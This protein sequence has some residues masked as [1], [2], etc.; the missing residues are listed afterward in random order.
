MSKRELLVLCGTCIALLFFHA[1]AITSEATA[2]EAAA[3]ELI[4]DGVAQKVDIQILSTNLA[5]GNTRGEWGLSALVKV[6]GRCILFD[7]GRFPDTVVENA[8]A[9]RADLSCVDTIVLSHFHFDHTGGLLRLVEAI[10]PSGEGPPIK[11]YVAEGFFTPRFLDTDKAVG[12]AMADVFGV[13]WNQMIGLKAELEQK[14]LAF[15]VVDEPTQIM[16]GVWATG[17]I[18]R[19]YKEENYPAVSLLREA[20]GETHVDHVPDSQGL[21]IRTSDGPIVIS[22]CGHAGAVNLV[23]K[24]RRDIQDQPVLALMGGL[25]LF[26]ASDEVLA[27][28]GK[29]LSRLGV[30]YLMAGHCTGVQPMY[31]LRDALGLDRKS[32]VIGAVG[33]RFELGYGIHPTVIAQ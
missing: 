17:P 4:A 15:V 30:Q 27:W 8:K 5:D 29:E 33:A 13:Q 24:V 16:A 7:A 11:T 10:R 9:L 23:T 22:G 2:S 20:A 26:N 18:E 32:A 14:G 1:S 12:A 19:Q 21:V 31:A 25:H 28:T 6:D 3:S